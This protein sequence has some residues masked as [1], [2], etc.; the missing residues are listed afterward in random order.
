MNVLAHVLVRNICVQSTE[1][2]HGPSSLISVTSTSFQLLMVGRRVV[3]DLKLHHAQ[4]SDP[5][6]QVKGQSISC[7]RALR[8][9]PLRPTLFY[10]M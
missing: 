6:D 10:H 8:A 7:I 2:I 9:V 3:R 1:F 4:G 5:T